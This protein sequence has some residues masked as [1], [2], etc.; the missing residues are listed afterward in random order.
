MKQNE[1][2]GILGRRKLFRVLAWICLVI[3][4]VLIIA[5]LITGITGSKYFVPCLV[6]CMILPFMMYIILWI[7]KV[8]AGL[9]SSN[10]DTIEK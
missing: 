9:N 7:G 6:L 1:Y 2:L 8:L 5:T 4:A 3:I 10:N